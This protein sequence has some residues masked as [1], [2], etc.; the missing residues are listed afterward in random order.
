MNI[1]ND[2]HIMIS[3]ILQITIMAGLLGWSLFFMLKRVAPSL[4]QNRQHQFANL[5]HAKGWQKLAEWFKPPISSN[6]GCGSG[7]NTCGS[8]ASNP[9]QTAEQ[10]V[11]WKHQAPSKNS[12]CD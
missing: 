3:N 11:N 8:C 5:L 6:N 7:C 10:A 2:G 4:V 9:N 12:G 1:V